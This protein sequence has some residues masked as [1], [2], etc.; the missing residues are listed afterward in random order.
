MGDTIFVCVI[1]VLIFINCQREKDREHELPPIEVDGELITNNARKASAFVQSFSSSRLVQPESH[2]TIDIVPSRSVLISCDFSY[3]NVCDTLK[4]MKKKYLK[5]PPFASSPS[6]PRRSSPN[7]SGPA[8]G[9]SARRPK[10]SRFISSRF[11]RCI[12]RMPSATS[13]GSASG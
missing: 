6:G 7:G 8:G 2:Y 1:A 5:P 10:V 4:S 11:S 13:A 9:T 12:R 3:Q